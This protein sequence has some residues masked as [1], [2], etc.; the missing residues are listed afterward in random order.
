MIGRSTIAVA[1]V[2]L[3]GVGCGGDSDAASRPCVVPEDEMASIWDADEMRASPQQN[4]VDCL[5]ASEDGPLVTLSVRTRAQFEAER[6]R[7]ESGGVVLP[8]LEPISGFAQGANVDP[9]YNS[10]NVPSGDLVVSVQLLGPEP[11]SFDEQLALEKTI[12]RAALDRV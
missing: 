12:A 10:L 9:R 2:V 7:F 11:G 6:A 4:G 8:P 5:Y 3:A 1:L